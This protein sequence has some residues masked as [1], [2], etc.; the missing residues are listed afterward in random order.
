VVTEKS[1]TWPG[2]PSRVS[3]RGEAFDVYGVGWGWMW[4]CQSTF[5]PFEIEWEVRLWQ[6]LTLQGVRSEDVSG[7]LK[8]TTE[9]SAVFLGANYIASSLALC[10][11]SDTDL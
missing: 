7:A 9:R 3:P 6:R 11:Q 1:P 2:S 10:V 8:R 4:S 5:I